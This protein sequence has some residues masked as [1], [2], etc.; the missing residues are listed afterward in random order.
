VIRAIAAAL[1]LAP[2]LLMMGGCGG[3]ADLDQA[4]NAYPAWC[5]PAELADVPADVTFMDPDVLEAVNHTA[6]TVELGLWL[7][8][9]NGRDVIW[10]DDS[11]RGWKRDDAVR[12]ELCHGKTFRRPGNAGNGQWHR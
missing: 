5:T 11:L 1:A 7:G 9:P 2:L 6:G 4:G 12:H 3:Q 10:I 8:N